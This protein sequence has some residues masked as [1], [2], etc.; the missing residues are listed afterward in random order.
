MAELTRNAIAQLREQLEEQRTRAEA[1]EAELR[2][3]RKLVDDIAKTV[4]ATSDG[5]DVV[6]FVERIVEES[7]RRAKLIHRLDSDKLNAARDA[8]A[9]A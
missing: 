8:E 6:G 3:L 4:G 9:L 7:I 2:E 1:A 5:A